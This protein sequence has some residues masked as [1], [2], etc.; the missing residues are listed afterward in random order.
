MEKT[1]I[2][3]VRLR[4][5]LFE[6][7]W[8][9]SQNCL[10]ETSQQ[11]KI[12]LHEYCWQERKNT[13]T[14]DTLERNNFPFGSWKVR[15]VS[16]KKN[17]EQSDF[18]VSQNFAKKQ[19]HTFKA[20]VKKRKDWENVSVKVPAESLFA[21]RY[22]V[23]VV[24]E[25][26]VKMVAMV[27]SRLLGVVM[28]ARATPSRTSVLQFPLVQHL[29][30]RWKK[31]QNKGPVSFRWHVCKECG[32]RKMAAVMSWQ[33]RHFFPGPISTKNSEDYF[34]PSRTKGLFDQE[35]MILR[36]F[37]KSEPKSLSP[38]QMSVLWWERSHLIGDAHFAFHHIPRPSGPEVVLGTKRILHVLP[39]SPDPGCRTLTAGLQHTQC[40]WSCLLHSRGRAPPDSCSG[41]W[42]RT[43]ATQR[44]IV[45]CLRRQCFFLIFENAGTAQGCKDGAVFVWS[46]H[47]GVPWQ[48]TDVF[49]VLLTGLCG[50]TDPCGLGCGH[51]RERSSECTYPTCRFLWILDCGEAHCGIV[52][53]IIAAVPLARMA[54]HWNKKAQIV[55][56]SSELNCWWTFA[57]HS[58]R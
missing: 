21:S 25:T 39:E 35:H 34:N 3:H 45:P 11:N 55:L 28:K 19:T 31:V 50:V 26:R 33:I 27:R 22:N 42:C 43:S 30:H 36:V 6:T 48:K 20:S 17:S 32:Q 29:A 49:F 51:R 54:F 4:H 46:P 5:R 2:Q 44:L 53:I 16:E 14:V 15:L 41:P 9:R 40:R 7:A 57:K 24:K 1:N 58:S 10:L 23:Q 18:S 12:G 38:W 8:W 56:T 52:I 13:C 37:W 47:S